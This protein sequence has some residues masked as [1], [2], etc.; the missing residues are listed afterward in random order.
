MIRLFLGMAAGLVVAVM[1][2]PYPFNALLA[3]YGAWTLTKALEE[4]WP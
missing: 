2:A 3:I 4:F 1:I